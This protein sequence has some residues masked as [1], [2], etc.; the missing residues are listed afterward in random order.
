[1]QRI[2][3]LVA[4]IVGEHSGSIISFTGDGLIVLFGVPVATSLVPILA[5]IG[6]P[7]SCN[8]CVDWNNKYVPFP[9]E[10]LAND[11][12]Y[13]SKNWPK[14][15]IGFHDPN[16]GVRFDETMDAM[17][18]VPDGRRSGYIM[19]SSLHPE[20]IALESAQEHELRLLRARRRIMGRLLEQIGRPGRVRRGEIPA[21]GGAFR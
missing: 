12:R 6:C 4:E 14:M 1:M 21:R 20:A 10:N 18:C 9:A 3:A 17:E 11:L 15:L 8:F 2:F 5:S 13:V 19:E 7:Y 16:F